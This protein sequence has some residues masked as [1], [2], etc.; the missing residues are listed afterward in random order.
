MSE[1]SPETNSS[2]SPSDVQ[3]PDALR[4]DDRKITEY[5]LNDAHAMGAPKAAFFKSVG[6]SNPNIECL[7]STMR[8][9]AKAN[10]I[11]QSSTGP[12]GTKYVID[13]EIEM[14]NGKKYCI[15]T[16][17]TDHH[18][19]PTPRLITAHPLG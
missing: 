8:D 12:Y 10:P 16:V 13:C 11:A 14:P 17:W 3:N 9:H 15:R 6:F 5:L 2:A 1:I 4:I 19:G 18:D 7:K